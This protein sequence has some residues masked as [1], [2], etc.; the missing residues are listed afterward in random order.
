MRGKSRRSR[1][2]P[3]LAQDDDQTEGDEEQG[4]QKTQPPEQGWDPSR[5]QG[6]P[7]NGFPRGQTFEKP[8]HGLPGIAGQEPLG[9]V[10]YDVLAP[11]VFGG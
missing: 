7:G 11:L 8:G 9:Q 2:T 5:Q 6:A 4:P 3:L 10:G 1:S